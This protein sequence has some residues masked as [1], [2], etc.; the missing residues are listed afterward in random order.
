MGQHV[1]PLL[2]FVAAVVVVV[3]SSMSSSVP[4]LWCLVDWRCACRTPEET[5]GILN[6]G[7]QRCSPSRSSACTPQEMT[8]TGKGV[9]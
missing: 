7:G 4:S 6:E 8:Q 3:I 1:L 2:E 5:T 9:G